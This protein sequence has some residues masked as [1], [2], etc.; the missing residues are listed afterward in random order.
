MKEYLHL[1]DDANYKSGISKFSNFSKYFVSTLLAQQTPLKVY[2]YT[3]D[4][5]N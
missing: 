1:V 4:R 2:Q 3:G 5:I